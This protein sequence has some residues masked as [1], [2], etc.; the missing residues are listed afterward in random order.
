[1]AE[2]PQTP[3]KNWRTVKLA[4]GT[5]VQVAVVKKKGPGHG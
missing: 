1:M 4:N 5:V 3:G 2:K